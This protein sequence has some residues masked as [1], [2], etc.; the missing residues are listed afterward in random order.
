[1]RHWR[2]VALLLF[3]G[4]SGTV[5]VI[6]DK[7]EHV[8]LRSV[9]EIWGDVLRDA[10]SMG[11]RVTRISAEREM[12]LGS[13]LSLAM[14]GRMPVSSEWD[15]YVQEVGQS[16]VPF[17]NRKAIEYEFKV[18]DTPI[19]N[20]FALP[21][22]RI[23]ITKGLLGFIQNE[24]ELAAILGHEMSH[25][26]L[27]HC[28]ER[29]QYQLALRRIGMHDLSKVVDVAHPIVVI[30]YGRYEELEA[31]AN[32]LRLS[33]AAGYDPSAAAAVFRRMQ[34]APSAR[35]ATRAKTPF[36]EATGALKGAAGEY[37]QS[38]PPTTERG[39]RLDQILANSRFRM[40]G[41]QVYVGAENYRRRIGRTRL[42]LV[43]ETRRL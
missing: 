11:F 4:G 13:D 16:L 18:V 15:S 43:G 10:D 3:I 41:R 33:A 26:D 28:V 19:L 21:G 27:R 2:L 5:A 20:A 37:F 34:R 17:V 29:Y 1:M 7:D 31:D 6:G 42:F 23:F 30:G 12:Q 24:A 22:G 38:H 36:G 39:N 35:A 9:M 25:V 8:S 14:F 32:G 40:S